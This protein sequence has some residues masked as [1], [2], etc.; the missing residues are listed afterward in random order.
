MI[1]AYLAIFYIFIFI[2]F[3]FLFGFHFHFHFLYIFAVCWLFVV[4]SLTLVFSLSL[5]LIPSYKCC[6]PL[7]FTTIVNI[8]YKYV[9]IY[10]QMLLIYLNAGMLLHTYFI[11]V[12]K[13]VCMNAYLCDN[14]SQ[15]HSALV[16]HL[17]IYH[18]CNLCTCI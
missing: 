17:Y 10:W 8:I 16:V 1:L 3:I 11:Y 9:H 4:C 13:Y 5:S 6:F 7:L 12:C 2:A 15:P 14:I 18:N